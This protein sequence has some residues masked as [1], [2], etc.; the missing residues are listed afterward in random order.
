MVRLN[1]NDK[2][3]IHLV[4]VLVVPVLL[5]YYH[6]SGVCTEEIRF[7]KI[8]RARQKLKCTFQLVLE[9]V[10][11]LVRRSE[12]ENCWHLRAPSAIGYLEMLNRLH[13]NL[14]FPVFYVP[15]THLFE[16]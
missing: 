3:V 15:S 9:D 2:V 14:P 6:V 12:Y 5:Y 11:R 1:D 10:N 8:F 7:P 13:R 4:Y 16:A